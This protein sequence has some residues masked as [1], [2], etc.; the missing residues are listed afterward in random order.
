MAMLNNNQMV[1]P[2]FPNKP[3]YHIKLVGDIPNP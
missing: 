3:N 2:K 1:N